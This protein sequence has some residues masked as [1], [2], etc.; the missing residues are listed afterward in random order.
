MQKDVVEGAV[1]WYPQW[2]DAPRWTI[3]DVVLG[4]MKYGC[5]EALFSAYGAFVE[6]DT[7]TD[8]EIGGAA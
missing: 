6:I 7:E 4:D 5:D 8:S 1:L 3:V 2:E